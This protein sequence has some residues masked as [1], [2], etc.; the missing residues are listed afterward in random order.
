MLV[1]ELRMRK[2]RVPSKYLAI[3][4]LRSEYWL[5]V[6]NMTDYL[7]GGVEVVQ[8]FCT[9]DKETITSE[10]NFMIEYFIFKLAA[11]NS[12]KGVKMRKILYR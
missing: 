2:K 12:E 10:L 11:L 7:V 4:R 6:N 8:I 5:E 9:N 1:Y 3:G